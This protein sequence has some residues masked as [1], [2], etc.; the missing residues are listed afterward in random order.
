[1]GD[2]YWH[3]I[4]VTSFGPGCGRANVPDVFTRISSYSHWIQS[5]IQGHQHVTF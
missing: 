1:M 3:L 2:G 5:V 4:G